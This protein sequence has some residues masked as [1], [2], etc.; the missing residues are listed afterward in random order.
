MKTTVRDIECAAR[1]AASGDAEG[2]TGELEAEQVT[3]DDD[4]AAVRVTLYDPS[5]TNRA[6][7]ITLSL[8]DARAF[9]AGLLHVAT[10]PTEGVTS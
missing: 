5:P 3:L 4:R 2:W 6:F 10:D 7:V 8:A 9:A 1:D